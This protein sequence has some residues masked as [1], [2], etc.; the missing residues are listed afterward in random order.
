L[1]MAGSLKGAAD[2]GMSVGLVFGI[3]T[4]LSSFTPL[5]TGLLADQFGLDS[6]FRLLIIL[7]ILAALMTFFFFPQKRHRTMKLNFSPEV[8]TQNNFDDAS[9]Q[10]S[11]R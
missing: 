4:T 11:K 10:R 7:P 1:T 8:N 6:A 2:V 9:E 3:S 5:L